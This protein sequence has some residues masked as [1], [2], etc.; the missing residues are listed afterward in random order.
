MDIHDTVV[1]VQ[2]M[3]Y[4]TV[5]APLSLVNRPGILQYEYIQRINHD[6]HESCESL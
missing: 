2:Y 1:Q 5:G 3:I 6:D 4:V